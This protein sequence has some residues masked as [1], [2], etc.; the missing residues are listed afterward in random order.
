[1]K[2]LGLFDVAYLRLTAWYVAI[3]MAISLAF[4]V[5]VYNQAA[6]ELRFGLQ[7]SD[8]II[9]RTP[10]QAYIEERLDVTR[11]RLIGNLVLLNVV[12]LIAGAGASYLLA[13]RTMQPIVDAVDAQERFTADASH[14]LRTPLAAMK[15][16]IEVGLRDGKITKDEAVELLK[17]NLEE[18]DRLGSLAEGLLT[19]TQTSDTSLDLK[20]V[21]LEDVAGDVVKRLQPLADVKKVTIKKDLQPV[22]AQAN[23][24][25]LEKIIG[26]LI[27]NAIKYSP[28][29]STVTVKTYSRD[30]HAV[31]EVSDQGI[32][33][34]ATELPHIFDRFYRADTSRTKQTVTGHGLGLSI[35]QK[36]ATQMNTKITAKSTPNQGSVFSITI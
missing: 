9:F 21:S 35:A 12:V 33:I 26:I 16:E 18:V 36:L 4:S 10:A 31:I 1:M 27:D 7:Q 17:S 29:K 15:S 14:E 3:I 19:L 25:A 22:I 32:G 2:P 24:P 20:S 5:W 30:S 6:N 23:E 8:S 11:Q 28:E 34:K 13:R